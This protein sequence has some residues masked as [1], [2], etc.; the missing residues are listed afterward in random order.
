MPQISQL[1]DTYFS[2]I[3][4]M[5]VFFGLTFFVV[6]RGLVP[7]VMATMSQRT[8]TITADLAAAEA[9]RAAAEAEASAWDEA[10]T[11]Q[12]AEA[13]ALIADAK[14]RAAHSMHQR[15][16][17]A[18]NRLDAEIAAAETAIAA[19]RTAA[20]AEFEAMAADVAADI[21]ARVAGLGVSA[22]EAR[23]AVK[24]ALAHA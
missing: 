16:A 24:G 17:D 9:A 19:A 12:R 6:G 21:T 23:E 3:F 15:L 13:H 5:V 1:A 2:Q 18:T 14:A 7:K 8:A 22:D 10:E 20:R 4:W 11:R